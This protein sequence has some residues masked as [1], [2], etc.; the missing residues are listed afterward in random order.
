MSRLPA[1]VASNE[2]QRVEASL[3]PQNF[4]QYVGQSAVV[5]KL[6][7]YVAAARARGDALDHCLFSGPPG[8]GKT[9]LAYI[10]A[11]ELGV[12]L[13]VTSG[14]AL[15]RK[16]DL[17]GLLINL[18]PARALH[19][20]IHRLPAGRVPL[21]GD[22]GLL[23]GHHHRLRRGPGG[24]DRLAALHPHRGT[25]RTGL[26]TSP[27]GG[28]RSGAARLP[29]AGRSGDDPRPQR[30]HLGITQDGRRRSPD[31]PGDTSAVQPAPPPHP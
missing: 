6:K 27:P 20:E 17:T 1:E 23:A 12:G 26:L 3:R 24:E 2:E 8:L 25:T 4:Q 28:S 16:G 7:I 22:G 10:V 5:E 21:S 31:G 19:D 29:H 15:E 13:H 11:G 30:L 18:Q 14:P 9:S